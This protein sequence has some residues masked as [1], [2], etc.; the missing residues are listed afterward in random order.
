MRKIVKNKYDNLIKRRKITNIIILLIIILIITLSKECFAFDNTSIKKVEYSDEFKEWLQLS[1]EEKENV[2]QPRMYDVIYTSSVSESPL[3]RAKALY[4]RINS[5]YSLKDIIPSNLTI[6]NQMQT[7]SCWTFASLSSLETNLA[8]SDLEEGKDTSI[9][10]FSERHME[11][12]TS[13][14]FLY[15]K[16]NKYGYNRSVDS[17]GNYW[18]AQSYLINGSG[19]IAES[20]MPFENNSYSIDISKIQ[21]KTVLTQVDDTIYFADYKD[22]NLSTEEQTQIINQIKQHLQND[23]SVYAMIH[24]ADLND[25]TCYNNKTGALYCSSSLHKTNHAVSII[26]WDDNYSKDNFKYKPSSN[27]AWII[28]NSWGGNEEYNLL[29]LKEI[30]FNE[31]KI[32]CEAIGWTKPED[33]PN[34]IIEY[35]GYEIKN[36]KAYKNIGDNGIMYVSYEDVNISKFLWGIVKAQNSVN[37][38]NIYQYDIYYPANEVELQSSNVCMYNIFNRTNTEVEYLTQVSLHA[39]ETYNCKVYVNPNGIDVSKN[40]I[41][42]VKLKAGESETITTGYHTLEF[43]KPI[44]LTGKSF[45]VIIEI[46]GSRDTVN[47]QLESKINDVPQFDTVIVE[48]GKCFVGLGNNPGETEWIDL[49]TLSEKVS[50]ITGGDSTIKAFT[51]NE[52]IDGSLKNIEIITPPNKTSYIEGQNFD[53]TGM[54]VKAYYNSR[55]KPSEILDKS[56][57][58][59]EDGNKL[60]IGQNSVTIKCEDKVVKQKINVE[61]NSVTNL[62]IKKLPTKTQYKEGEN[63]YNSGMVVQATYKDGTTKIISNYTISDG[64]NLQVEQTY[65]T[66]SFEGISIKQAIKVKK[67]PLLEIKITR[68]P[69]KV[70]YIVGQ[71]FDKTGMLVTGIYEDGLTTEITNYTIK[72][73]ENL[74]EEQTSVTIEFLGK[75]ETQEITVEEKAI[76]EISIIEKPSKLQYIQNKENLNLDGGKLRVK[77]NDETTETILLNSKEIQVTKFDNTKLG[78]QTITLTYKSKTTELEIEIIQEKIVQ[79]EAKSSELGSAK[80][81]IKDVKAYYFTSSLEEDYVLIDIEITDI[82]RNFENDKTEYYY[83]LSPNKGET[84]ITQWIKIKEEQNSNVKLEFTINTQDIDYYEKIANEETM[85]LYIKE[86]ATKG[87]N[88]KIATTS[89]MELGTTKEFE[90]YINNKKIELTQINPNT[91]TNK[92]EEPDNT[93]ASGKLPQAGIT[94][95]II[96]MLALILT[97]GVIGYSKYKNLSK[98]IK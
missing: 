84:N 62:E 10:D 24:G 61:K 16:I 55:T 59:I 69:D 68:Q 52:L 49:S 87:A 90:I 57:Y 36:D 83:Y 67:N 74:T 31:N 8:L 4:A 29:E 80:C 94:T 19:A 82:K 11:Y 6:R 64:N 37:Y 34:D 15:N 86:I 58:N 14:T 2:I 21:D 1:E 63:F 5:R 73:G 48:K 25:K 50:T 97:R 3:Y 32:S 98:Y 85:Y 88:Q 78:K 91:N 79:E 76:T 44:A 45:A 9:Y 28:R 60:K 75:T 12:A 35:N 72:N 30:I 26:G 95:I 81:N 23:G 70:K 20:E 47:I 38:D 96:C 43:E 42:L 93:L 92:K 46:Q 41:Q 33:I 39:A 54:V 51:T 13:K 7:G 17:G 40:S 65:V 56:L 77:Y 18:M 71:N 22:V 66:I 89:G 27:G 53:S